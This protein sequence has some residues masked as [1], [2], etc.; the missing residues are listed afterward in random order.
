MT[1][2]LPAPVDMTLR[3]LIP[4]IVRT[5]VPLL[6]AF[7]LRIGLTETS[8]DQKWVEWFITGVVT[9]LYYIVVRVLEKHWGK[10]GWLLGYAAQPV[11]VRGDIVQAD[12][13]TTPPTQTTVIEADVTGKA[14]DERGAANPMTVLLWALA[15]IAVLV[16]V[17]LL[18]TLFD[19]DVD[20]DNDR[21]D[22]REGHS[23]VLLA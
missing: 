2:N 18:F 13:V 10:I 8:I 4:G 20:V 16:A 21:K 5:F 3:S 1:N 11:Y 15:A 12:E 7:L 9:M 14:R 17:Y 6:I 22:A 23:A 19:G